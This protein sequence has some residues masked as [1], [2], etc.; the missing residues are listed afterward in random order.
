M[1]LGGN[2]LFRPFNEQPNIG[3]QPAA[4]GGTRSRRC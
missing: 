1:I 3:F 2:Q 4:A